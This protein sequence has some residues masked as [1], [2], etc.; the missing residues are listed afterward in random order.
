MKINKHQ[1]LPL[2][3]GNP[4]NTPC[5][6]EV[7]FIA[8]ELADR[9]TL[10][11][12]LREGVTYVILDNA[13]DGLDQI[14]RYL[15]NHQIRVL[16]IVSHGGAG[17]IEIG[18]TRLSQDT[19]KQY[20]SELREIG[21][22]L[23][24]DAE[25]HIYSCNVASTSAGV[26]FVEQLSEITGTSVAASE[27]LTGSASLGGDW[28]LE[29]H[30]GQISALM[31]FNVTA[32]QAYASVL[33]ATDE[34]FDSLGQTDTINTSINV[35]SWTFTANVASEFIVADDA[36]Y[37]GYLNG[38]ADQSLIWN[39]DSTNANVFSFYATDQSAFQL[40][41]FQLGE[42]SGSTTVTITTYLNTGLVGFAT[43][44]LN[45]SS[46][47][48]GITYTKDSN[49]DF[50]VLSFNSSY[51]NIDKVQLNFSGP[52]MP[53]IDSI[54]VS[55]AV[56]PPTIT[57][58]TFDA[59]TGVLTVTGTNLT[60]SA[61]NDVDVSKLSL[62]GE[63]GSPYTLTSSGVEI[64][65]STSF[66]VS[67]NGT[68]LAAVRQFLNKNGTSSTSGTT[69]NIGGALG[70]LT[71][72]ASASD[73]SGNSVTVTN[74]AV[75]AITS[76]TYD[77]ATGAL[78]VTGSGF[79]LLNGV[80]NDIDV[81]KLTFT[82]EGG[83]TYT[84]TTTS[85]D[86][87]SGTSFTVALNAT[88]LANVNQI[89]NKNGTSATGAITYNLAA[90]ENWAAGADAA[91]VVADLTG[92]GI[93]ASNVPIPAITSATYDGNTGVVVV[94]G[95]GFTHLS[96][97]T[98]DIVANK[99]TF[100]GEGGATYTLTDTA[101][102]EITS[103]TSFILTL[104]ATDKAAV[105]LLLNQNGTS[106]AGATTY[107]IA[108]ADGWA[109]GASSVTT[110][111]ASGN[112]ITVSNAMD[113]TPPSAPSTPDMSAGTDSGS[114]STDNITNDT[115]PTFSG[116]A[117]ANA[118][119]RLFDTDGTT[120][121]GSGTADGSGNWTITSTALSTGAHSITAKATDAS[122]NTSV[123]SS[124]LS[125]TVDTT[126]P[127]APSAPDMTSGTDT[128]VSNS[129]DITN[130]TTPTFTGTTEA[131]ASVTMYDTD[132][133]T[134]LG[135]A[136]ADGSGNW[137][138][139]SSILSAGNHTLTTK[140]TDVAGNVSSASSGLSI[141]ID[142]TAPSVSTI[143]RVSSALTNATS[144]DYMV[145]FAEA[146]YGV[147][148]TDF[149]LT[150]TGT[151]TGSVAT[152]TQVN[153]NTFTIT[154][155]TLTGD[156]TL[157]LDLKNSGTGITDTAGNA[158][159]TGFTL[160]Q[161]YT[162]DHTAPAVTSVNVP[163]NATY[164]AGQHLDFTVNFGENVTVD[165]TGGTPYVALTLD[166]GGAVQAS[167]L[168]GSGTAALAFRYTVQSGNADANGITVGALSTNGGTL[169]DAAGN[170]ATLTL[171]S[172]GSTAAVLVDAI[173]PTTSIASAVFSA[174]TGTSPT[175]FITAT[176]AQN[177]S[178]TLS[179]N[180]AA[181]ES[182]EVSLDNGATW[183]TATA[184]VGQNTWSLAGQTLVA[185]DALKVRVSDIDGSGPT[186]SQAYVLDI[187]SPTLQSTTPAD[188]ATAVAVAADVVI[189]FDES[190][191][192]VAGKTINLYKSADNSLVETIAV[193]DGTK[194][195]ITGGVVTINPT[196]DFAETTGY[197]VLV[198]SGAFTDMAGNVYGGITSTTDFNFTTLTTP[199]APSGN[200][201][202][203]MS[204]TT[205]LDNATD[206]AV[207]TA[208]VMSFSEAIKAGS[209]NILISNVSG[210]RS[211]A[212]VR[213]ISVNDPQILINGRTLTIDLADPLQPNSA[214][215]VL[216]DNGAITDLAG[217][218]FTGITN[219]T[220][221]NFVTASGASVNP[222]P[223]TDDLFLMQLYRDILYREADTG[224]LS[225][226]TQLLEQNQLSR[227]SV[228][229]AFISSDEFQ[230]VV[231]SVARLYFGTFDRM[232]DQAG[233]SYW[234]NAL[235]AGASLTDIGK[236]FIESDEFVGLYGTQDGASFLGPL[237]NHILD[238][239]ADLPG[240]L[241]W[242][243]Q[244]EAGVSKGQILTL[245]TN[246]PEYATNS[247]PEITATLT[248]L[249]L[250]GT[251]PDQNTLDT[252]VQDVTSGT[253]L[254]EIIGTMLN[255]PEYHDRFL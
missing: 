204:V 96:G 52:S 25:I 170:N 93:T 174:D 1:S 68:D 75:P 164:N 64:T 62:S 44:N 169:R 140:A 245:F 47:I 190:V 125:I 15:S 158:I 48:N 230:D 160:G 152:V 22:L 111:D 27:N 86:I 241:Y 205:P 131:N 42:L 211:L 45:Q 253:P 17:L 117:E 10:I 159:A 60:A 16:H 180:L 229:E 65:S 69:Y 151:A 8:S 220:A 235:R 144:V 255:S 186:L 92:N 107:N 192:S 13:R 198:D 84:L 76:A 98:N 226:W 5:F 126:A 130:D 23:D 142:T 67:L 122:N 213:T 128:G 54:D 115:T 200:S 194:V 85:V 141:S 191:A 112:G 145:S 14:A 254:I 206:V 217:M 240:L 56:V 63:G 95:T 89:I 31:A 73:T 137:S 99:F 33:A 43:I 80:N 233:L 166:T 149:S 178:G 39:A 154:A 252:L 58:A 74:V 132:G 114:S 175:D 171:N 193:N 20:E 55:A 216:I 210:A 37:P 21:Q 207:D 165:T 26:A 249:G 108:A 219:P 244:L 188:N 225:F 136:T 243:T 201:A 221:F 183:T 184:T 177:I 246:S 97:A 187:T 214:Y 234:V 118:T 40:N 121:L 148:T 231:G 239:E 49:G 81:S 156:G 208:I 77:A 182:V 222:L 232:P 66:S 120:Q 224:G 11:Q 94:T 147:D 134:V 176:A 29:T 179:A 105:D 78:V 57:S 61:G 129:D 227:E 82:G 19:L 30:I 36:L 195:G 212:D 223:I 88:D 135:T 59:S 103:G 4:S 251:L 32:V 228:A 100:T 34:N 87:T 181:G 79:L 139:T 209:G 110:T 247:L 12:T 53:E 119:V 143:N 102:V 38:S 162:L 215:H 116:T 70:W 9:A 123:A 104:S 109:A 6:S 236:A 71:A 28:N 146:V 18:S 106:S 248:S 163:G 167:Y 173:P 127:V 202:P 41:S 153:A 237:Y 50:G 35:G 113:S 185:S 101:N 238:R 51:Q 138:I 83:S 242:Q 133:T 24:T 2:V 91:V 203:T 46:S 172:V 218:A 90:A 196:A 155:N 189:S 168:S 7:A 161:T 197:Y 124:G 150:A 72:D 199:P 3:F 157:R 250:L